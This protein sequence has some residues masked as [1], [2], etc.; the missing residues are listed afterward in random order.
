ML[1]TLSLLCSHTMLLSKL[2][3]TVYKTTVHGSC[4]C[5]DRMNERILR[6]K[7]QINRKWTRGH[8]QT[9]IIHVNEIRDIPVTT[10]NQVL[11]FLT[12]HDFIR[13]QTK[14]PKRPC[15]LSFHGIE[16]NNF[17]FGLNLPSIRAINF[18]SPKKKAKDPNPSNIQNN[19]KTMIITIQNQI[20]S[21]LLIS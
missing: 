13:T 17:I 11:P 8:A 18:S 1:I 6:L 7:K 3:Q 10:S 5:S 9:R 14:N 19:N 12:A 20:S 16:S 21:E 2:K 4:I 15:K